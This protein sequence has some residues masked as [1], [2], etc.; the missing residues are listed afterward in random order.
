MAPK[1]K[2]VAVAGARKGLPG[3]ERSEPLLAERVRYLQQENTALSEQLS[4][5]LAQVERMLWE[6]EFLDREAQHIREENKLFVAYVGTR[7]HRCQ[8]TVVTLDGH[9]RQE[10]SLLRGQREE[11]EATYR[12]KEQEVRAQ[13]LDMESRFAQMARE[14]RELQPYKALQ[15][16]QQ[17]RI[18]GLEQQL[19]QARLE[20]TRQLHH[21]KSSFLETKASQERQ[22][23]QQIH[24]LALRAERE[25]LH[26]LILHTQTI[27]DE[28]ARLRRELLGLIT[29]ARLLYDA[30]RELREQR[31]LLRWESGFGRDL[32]RIHGWL[33]RS[34]RRDP[35][36]P[37]PSA[38]SAS[39][40][41]APSRPAQASGP[42]SAA[43][44]ASLEC[45][46]RPGAWRG[47]GG[48]GG[49]AGRGGAAAA[50]ADGELRESALP[51][52]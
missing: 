32:A 20:H 23:E 12:D 39:P 51:S 47:G 48:E 35:D 36:P 21:V 2:K 31:E 6:N 17:A 14:V 19:L 1:K 22:A 24:M 8:S 33:H 27:K 25:A 29:R 52:L 37:V 30:R 15:Q 5:W 9:Y 3:G 46:F 10:L 34:P 18:R 4:T 13:L 42:A 49:E 16:E 43:M 44:R 28:N 7:A 40:G 26:T 41:P 11:L 38:C 45:P 50:A